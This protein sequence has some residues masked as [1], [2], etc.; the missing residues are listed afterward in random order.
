MSV[1]ICIAS[2]RAP[3][4][5]MGLDVVAVMCCTSLMQCERLTLRVEMTNMHGGAQ[6]RR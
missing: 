2:E 3:W 1:K 4:I 5:L 6:K